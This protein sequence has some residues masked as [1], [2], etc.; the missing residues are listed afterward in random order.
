M[1]SWWQTASDEQVGTRSH[2]RCHPLPPPPLPLPPPLP[3]PP[4]PPNPGASAA[5]RTALARCFPEPLDEHGNEGVPRRCD[6]E[7]IG[8]RLYCLNRRVLEAQRYA[9][10]GERQLLERPEAR[11]VQVHVNSAIS[12]QVKV[13]HGVD[14]LDTQLV[15]V[16]QIEVVWEFASHE[17][18]VVLICVQQKRPVARQHAPALLAPE[19]LP[20]RQRAVLPRL[21]QDLRHGDRFSAG[22]PLLEAR[23][24]RLASKAERGERR[25][26]PA[27]GQSRLAL[28]AR[29]A[30]GHLRGQLCAD[31]NALLRRAPLT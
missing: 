18:T 16:V 29:A 11:E 22:L 13:A 24:Y 15:A 30:D 1:V 14:A 20:P 12:I 6:H 28:A 3:P 23:V 26:P 5:A 19:R 9:S 4:P 7:G 25:H 2:G 27:V 8:H 31:T 17:R 10:C 21:M